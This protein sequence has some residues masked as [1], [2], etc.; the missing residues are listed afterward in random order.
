MQGCVAHMV[1][2]Q[3]HGQEFNSSCFFSW[4]EL[5]WQSVPSLLIG[6]PGLKATSEWVFVVILEVGVATMGLCDANYQKRSACTKAIWLDKKHGKSSWVL[7]YT[8]NNNN[9][10]IHVFVVSGRHSDQ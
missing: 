2:L 8:K 3:C 5:L 10:K 4:N 9:I 1:A 6:E 7:L